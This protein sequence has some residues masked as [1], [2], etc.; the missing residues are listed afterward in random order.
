[1]NAPRPLPRW[2]RALLRLGAL[3]MRIIRRRQAPLVDELGWP[4]SRH[5]EDAMRELPADQEWWLANLAA[6][7][8]PGNEYAEMLRRDPPETGEGGVRS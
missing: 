8:W 3:A 2:R 7:L 1:M 5:P 6:E 4:T